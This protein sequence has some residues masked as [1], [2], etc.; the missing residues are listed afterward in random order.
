MTLHRSP[1]WRHLRR[2][3]G[4]Q[5]CG[6]LLPNNEEQRYTMRA[7]VVK[8][9]SGS[10]YWTVLDERMDAVPVAD[11]FLR[12]LRFGRDRAESTTKAYAGAVALYLRWCSRSDR[13]GPSPHPRSVCS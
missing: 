2:F 6:S 5:L 12:E 4:V 10:R 3:S 8:M 9:P 11:R 1:V 13:A 7:F